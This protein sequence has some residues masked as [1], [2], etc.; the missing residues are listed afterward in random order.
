MVDNILDFSR[1]E[2]GAR[3]YEHSPLDLRQVTEAALDAFRAASDQG[4]FSLQADLAEVGTSMGDAAALQQAIINLL[5]NAVKYSREG[6]PVEVRLIQVDGFAR[7]SVKDQG[8]GIPEEERGRIFEEFYRIERG[9]AQRSAG[10]G[11][12]LALVRRTVESHGGRVFVDGAPACGS[13]F[14]V[15]IPTTGFV[16]DEKPTD[17]NR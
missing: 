4:R 6:S 3:K 9:D 1:V 16:R 7:I 10:S 13:T 17:S 14:V 5:D 2:R 11:L 15:E 8:I 12:G